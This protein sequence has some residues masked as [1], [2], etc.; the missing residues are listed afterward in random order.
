MP[1]QWRTQYGDSKLEKADS[2]AAEILCE[3]ETLTVQNAPDADINQVIKRFGITDG[4][5]LPTSLGFPIGPEFYGDFSDIPDLRTALETQRQVGETFAQ[6][7]A[8]LRARFRN[9]PYALWEYV[10]DPKNLDEAV[11][12]GLLSRL[13][14]T[15]N[16]TVESG[17]N[18]APASSASAPNTP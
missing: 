3:D 7:P 2:K 17:T 18:N 11:Q 10:N 5:V 9:D 16:S 6:L 8:D 4:S 14:P 15:P 1:I 13:D 12:L